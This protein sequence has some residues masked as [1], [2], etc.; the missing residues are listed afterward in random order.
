MLEVFFSILIL[1]RAIFSMNSFNW[2]EQCTGE[3]CCGSSTGEL[4]QEKFQEVPLL[5]PWGSAG[6]AVS[7]CSHKHPLCLP[8]PAPP[9]WHRFLCTSQCAQRRHCHAQ[10]DLMDSQRHQS[11]PLWGE[12]ALTEWD[13]KHLTTGFKATENTSCCKLT[14]NTNDDEFAFLVL[15]L[16]MV[17]IARAAQ[18]W[19]SCFLK[20]AYPQVL[21]IWISFISFRKQALCIFSCLIFKWSSHKTWDQTNTFASSLFCIASFQSFDILIKNNIYLPAMNHNWTTKKVA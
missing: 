7:R 19:S 11:L 3:K 18:H 9:A 12:Q 15:W 1:S 10:R 6:A 17:L 5:G 20:S 16:N 21:S 13:W 14:G 4:W 8:R 2:T